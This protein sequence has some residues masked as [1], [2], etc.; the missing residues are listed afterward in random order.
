M[1]ALRL[2]RRQLVR[3]AGGAI[4]LPALSRNS[5][6]QA[7]P[8]RPVHLVVGFPPGGPTNLV[9]RIASQWLS[10]RLGQPFI[11]ENRPGAG[12][13]IA[14]E[15]VI[16]SRPDGYTLLLAASANAI[17]AML[18]DRLTVTEFMADADRNP[19]K[20]TVASAGNGTP[21]HAFA[22]LFKMM[23][24]LKML[25]VPYRGDAP[26]ITICSVAGFK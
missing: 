16:R 26:A 19:G 2:C 12:S 1:N 10:G 24:G 13:N 3:L 23:T 6:A 20:V 17:N 9:A 25:H 22:E 4:A 14:A 18:Y 7:Y 8:T 5:T 11:V 21:H 15:A